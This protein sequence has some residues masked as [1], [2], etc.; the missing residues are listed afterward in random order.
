METSRGDKSRS[1]GKLLHP[2]KTQ[3]PS[4]P[5]LSSPAAAVAAHHSFQ[6]SAPHAPSMLAPGLV[7]TPNQ[8]TRLS[9]TT[10]PTAAPVASPPGYHPSQYAPN[11]TG[12]SPGM[13]PGGMMPS[14]GGLPPMPSP[15][16]HANYY[17]YAG[18]PYHHPHHPPPPHSH[19]PQ[20]P[21]PS[22]YPLP[23]RVLV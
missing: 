9:T 10:T 8:K 18:P 19:P 6:S 7:S 20:H 11:S 5:A 3:G 2:A 12:K 13:A 22:A 21:P 1:E 23:R 16:H 15:H 14:P 17:P 4:K